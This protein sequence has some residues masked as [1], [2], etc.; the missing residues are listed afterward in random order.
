MAQS[1]AVWNAQN[2]VPFT[3]GVLSEIML[4]VTTVRNTLTVNWGTTGITREVIPPR[5]LYSAALTDHLRSTYIRYLKLASLATGLK[6][7]GNEIAYF[8]ED[9]TTEIGGQGWLN[10]LPV[11]GN[12]DNTTSQGL[13]EALLALL[14]FAHIK[15]AL[16]PGDEGLLAVLQNPASTLPNGDSQ[17]LTLT[18]WNSDSLNALLT[19]FGKNP[20]ELPIWMLSGRTSLISI[21][22]VAS[23]TPMQMSRPSASRPLRFSPTTT[24]EPSAVTART[25][26]L[27]LRARYGE[28]AWPLY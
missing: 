28:A 15:A 17:L 1:G 19:R 6:L 22:S 9:P 25:F 3:A 26:Q 27:A 21:P 7:T 14:D 13:R 23:T 2:P 12:P 24:N 18:G 8:A 11:S 10:A 4:T 5:F 20:F 16:S